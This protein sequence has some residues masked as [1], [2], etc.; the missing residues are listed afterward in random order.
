MVGPGVRLPNDAKKQ[1]EMV[2][3]VDTEGLNPSGFIARAGSSPAFHATPG[4]FAWS[5]L[6][7]KKWDE[8]SV[9]SWIH[10]QPEA[11]CEERSQI[12]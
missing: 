3:L 2:E 1:A 11:A 5:D 8:S 4:V 10:N 9:E 7:N 6:Q 12:D